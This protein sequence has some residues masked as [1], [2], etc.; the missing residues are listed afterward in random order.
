MCWNYD[1]L[2]LVW[3]SYTCVCVLIPSNLTFPNLNIADGTK[4]GAEYFIERTNIVDS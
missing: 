3:F 2:P 4:G 1:V